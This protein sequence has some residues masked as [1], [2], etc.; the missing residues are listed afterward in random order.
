[1]NYQE[2]ETYLAKAKDFY[3]IDSQVL[4]AL[5]TTEPLNE[6]NILRV[7]AYVLISFAAIQEVLEDLSV[8]ILEDSI[9]LY[10][11][12]QIVNSVI[13][14][15]IKESIISLNTFKDGTNENK[16]IRENLEMIIL[17][18]SQREGIYRKFKNLFKND[19]NGLNEKF[20]LVLENEL[21]KHHR[22][23]YDNNGFSPDKIEKKLFYFSQDVK[24]LLVG[25]IVT[26]LKT[27]T[28]ERGSFAHK[29]KAITIE[30]N[31][32]ILIDIIERCKQFVK[33]VEEIS[34]Q[35]K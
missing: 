25:M 9:E 23:I 24:E 26:D 19:P 17:S 22:I 3:E 1:M 28:K 33:D 30:R 13:I 15:L 18:L 11:Q 32:R 10:K 2:L 12:Q 7:R 14:N 5:Q 35:V 16:L 8:K 6:D 34:E 4:V 29:G 20:L 27:L 21:K 31:Y